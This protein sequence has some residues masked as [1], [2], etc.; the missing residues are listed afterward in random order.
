M[1]LKQFANLYYRLKDLKE[2]VKMKYENKM[3]M[4]EK[5]M[6]EKEDMMEKK[7]YKKIRAEVIK[8]AGMKGTR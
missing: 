1:D 3:E 7:I 2:Q 5:K 4:Q 6:E 8:K